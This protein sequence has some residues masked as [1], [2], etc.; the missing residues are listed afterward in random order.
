MLCVRWRFER[1]ERLEREELT[2]NKG[3]HPSAPCVFGFSPLS[4]RLFT[5]RTL[6][7]ATASASDSTSG[8]E[9]LI[10]NLFQFF[11][12]QKPTKL[13]IFNVSIVWTF[14][15]YVIR[16]GWEFWVLV[17]K[18]SKL[19]IHNHPSLSFQ[20]HT[21]THTYIHSHKILHTQTQE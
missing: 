9:L 7:F 20:T 4:R 13:R 19:K 21:H 10:L 17:S 12:N 8:L 3:V 14:G 6:P 18:K 16:V 11:E 15:Q 1:F 5:V 2:Y